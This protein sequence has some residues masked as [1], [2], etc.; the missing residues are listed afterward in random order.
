MNLD[1]LLRQ[2][3][4]LTDE[5]RRALFSEFCRSCGIYIEESDWSGL[6]YCYLCSPD[7]ASQRD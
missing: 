6:N 3:K 2:L 4:S 5:E 1:E 7:P